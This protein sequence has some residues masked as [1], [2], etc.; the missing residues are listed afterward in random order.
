[1]IRLE[2][3]TVFLTMPLSVAIIKFMDIE[4]KDVC[5]LSVFIY[6]IFNCIRFFQGDVHLLEDMTGA[7]RE[8]LAPSHNAVSFFIGIASKIAFLLAAYNINDCVMFFL[9]NGVCF[10]FDL[11][12]VIVLM[13]TLS[14]SARDD[15]HLNSLFKTWIIFDLVECIISFVAALLIKVYGSDIDIKNWAIIGSIVL[16][17]F[18]MILD[19]L[20]NIEH[21]FVNRKKD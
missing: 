3:L 6:F 13:R 5:V 17:S 19:Y 11:F 10:I 12:W 15:T 1:M 4:N 16:F 14:V 21:Y 18:L 8:E 7:Q 20:F 9:Y 2:I